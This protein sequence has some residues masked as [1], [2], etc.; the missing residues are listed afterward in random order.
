MLN[1]AILVLA[2]GKSSRM[3]A[4]KQLIKIKNKTL[5]DITLE[6]TKTLKNTTVFCVLGSNSNQIEKEIST[7]KIKIIHNN[8]YNDGLSSSI[9]S[10]INHFNKNKLC[11]DGVFILLADQPAIKSSY[12]EEMIELFQNNSS[13]IIASNY[14]HNFGVPAIIPSLFF[15]NLLKIK[16]DKGAKDFLNIH[17]NIIITPKSRADLID[18]DTK[19]DV[20]F[21]KKQIK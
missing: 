5:L 4:I 10:G 17:K 11:F 14:S 1:I 21:Y 8:N 18:L 19:E 6:K 16:G 20:D 2:A 12:Y 15:K 13:S 7:K 9:I 3:K